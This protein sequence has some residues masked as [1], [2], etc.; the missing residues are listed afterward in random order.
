MGR[1]MMAAALLLLFYPCAASGDP[2][3]FAGT[4]IP[5]DSPGYH[6]YEFD[7]P[8]GT[9]RIEVAYGHTTEGEQS[10]VMG[11]VVDIAIYDPDGFR[12]SSG[13]ARTDFVVA[14]TAEDTT[15]AYLPGPIPAGTWT[16][17]LGT[18]YIAS[19]ST[20]V[21]ELAIDTIAG[22]DEPFEPPA[23]EP[24]V[25][26]GAGWYRGDL[27]SHSLH[28][29]GSEPLEATFAFAH[30]VGLDFIAS[31]EHFTYSAHNEL[32]AQQ[33]LYGDMVLIRGVE[34]TSYRGHANVFGHTGYVDY[35]ASEPGYDVGAVIGAV[36]DAGGLFSVNHP[37]HFTVETEGGT[38][39]LGWTVPDTDWADVDCVEVVNGRSAWLGDVVNPLNE[40]AIALWDEVLLQGHRVTAVGGSDD[41]KAGTGSADED[42]Y[43]APIGTP[44][45]VVYAEE[46]SEAGILEALAA[47]HASVQAAGPDGPELY[48]TAV[49]GDDEG[50][51][52]DVVAGPDC[53]VTAQAVGGSGLTLRVIEDGL[54]A[55]DPTVSGDDWLFDIDA[56]PQQVS[57]VRV[58]LRDGDLLQALSNP[59][60]LEFAEADAE[61]IMP[62][63]PEDDCSCSSAPAPPSALLSTVVLLGLL[64]VRRAR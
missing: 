40:N 16:I 23:W 20:T 61:E 43:Y 26:G 64:L 62:Y 9:G 3:T 63:P 38:V 49:C 34:M 25:L 24:P 28:S 31:S 18:G 42:F 15:D 54:L 36:H 4:F 47:G 56:D 35:H 14:L 30:D 59:V 12:G 10:P 2:I 53:V 51:M 52:G 7:V 45:T 57:Y 41:H 46:L 60:Y 27:H 6:R 55:D 50:M 48:L 29:D 39:S 13:G 37:G 19:G 1:S 44:T 11:N 17:E 33:D 32:P 58:E 22:D 8:V 5:T 21:F